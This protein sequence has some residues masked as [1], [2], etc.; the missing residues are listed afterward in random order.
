MATATRNRPDAGRAAH[1]RL[2]ELAVTL[3]MALEA[4][5]G[6]Q[7]EAPRGPIDPDGPETWE[8]LLRRLR[9]LAGQLRAALLAV[10]QI[11]PDTVRQAVAEA[12]GAFLLSLCPC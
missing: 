2:D 8:Q 9:P 11:A 7:E 3:L 10:D 4:L 5:R 6:L 1:N 12:G